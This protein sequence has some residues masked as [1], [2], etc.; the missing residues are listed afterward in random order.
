MTA[1]R[2]ESLVPA[3]ER[4]LDPARQRRG[5][6]TPPHEPARQLRRRQSPGNHTNASGLPSISARIRSRTAYQ[7]GN[8]ERMSE[9]AP[10]A[11]SRPDMDKCSGNPGIPRPRTGR[12]YPA[13]GSEP[14][15]AAAPATPAPAPRPVPATAPHHTMHQRGRLPGHFRQG[16]STASTTSENDPAPVRARSNATPAHRAAGH[17]S[18]SSRYAWEPHGARRRTRDP[19]IPRH[20]AGQYGT[21][22]PT[23][24][25]LQQRRLAIPGSRA[26]QRAYPAAA[27]GSEHESTAEALSATIPQHYEPHRSRLRASPA[28][29][30]GGHSTPR[31]WARSGRDW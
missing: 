18:R 27:S 1:R 29:R 28:P 20:S 12:E 23:R 11:R 17:G 24:R 16:F 4:L 9:A 31:A 7:G 30:Y 19:S 14:R 8:A 21:P 22:G 25:V 26:I 5:T 2:R 13:I 10:D 6:Q 3:K 15:T